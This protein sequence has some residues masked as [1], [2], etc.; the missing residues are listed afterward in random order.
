MATPSKRNPSTQLTVVV[1][2]GLTTET[3]TPTVASSWRRE[4][5]YPSIAHLAAEQQ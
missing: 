4:T 2:P 3:E 1:A 5:A